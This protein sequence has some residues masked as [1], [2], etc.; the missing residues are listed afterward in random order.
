MDTLT[1]LERRYGGVWTGIK[2]HYGDLPEGEKEKESIRLCDAIIESFKRDILLPSDRIS[3]EGARRSLGLTR[4]EKAVVARLAEHAEI[5][6]NV[7]ERVVGTI[8][9]LAEGVTGLELGRLESP[10]IVVSYTNPESTMKMIR[11]WQLENGS[12]PIVE[13]TTF[14]AVCGN[15]MAAA[16]VKDQ[17]SITLGCPTSRDHE[18][19]EKETLIIGMPFGIAG[20]I[21]N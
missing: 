15:V 5:P 17:I 14:M 10:D 2:F 16:Y 11:T 7:A 21:V 13:L 8:P 6:V 9:R 1:K 12:G 3:C 20:S 18:L 19:V 4:D